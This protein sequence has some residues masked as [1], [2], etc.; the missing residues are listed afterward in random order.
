MPPERDADMQGRVSRL[1]SAIAMIGVGG[2]L[3]VA[4]ATLADVLMR[5]LFNAPFEGLE[6]I[7][8]LVFAVVIASCFPAALAHGNNITIRFLGKWL[9]PP[10]TRVLEVVGQT[11]VLLIFAMMALRLTGY[12]L[13]LQARGIGSL[14]YQFLE[15]PW[16]IAAA[17]LFWVCVPVQAWVLWRCLHALATGRDVS[18][19]DSAH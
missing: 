11:L 19:H 10:V 8:K 4:V 12:A 5:W 7:R 6:D 13:D 16:W 3:I 9:G 15:G 2:M 18:S 17:V 1:T 14:T